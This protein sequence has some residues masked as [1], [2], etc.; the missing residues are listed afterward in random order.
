[1]AVDATLERAPLSSASGAASGS[2]TPPLTVAGLVVTRT[3]LVAAL[4]LY[5]PQVADVSVLDDERFLLHLSGDIP[6]A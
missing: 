4:R 2:T 6:A 5:V 1:M 3:A